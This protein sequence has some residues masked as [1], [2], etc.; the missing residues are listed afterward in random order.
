M[1]KLW[2]KCLI[3]WRTKSILWLGCDGDIY[4]W[5]RRPKVDVCLMEYEYDRKKYA[6]R[7]NQTLAQTLRLE[8]EKMIALL[9][10]PI[11]SFC[12]L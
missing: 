10:T 8:V 11:D 2:R 7:H 4:K 12:L 6:K 9:Q 5:P 1:R 3:F